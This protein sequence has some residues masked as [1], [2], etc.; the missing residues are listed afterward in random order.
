MKKLMLLLLSVLV[1]FTGCDLTPSEGDALQVKIVCDT[2]IITTDPSSIVLKE[3]EADVSVQI[4][5]M[6]SKIGSYYVTLG[7]TTKIPVL[8]DN[9]FF[10]S[11]NDVFG[12]KNP[13]I[14]V[15]YQEQQE[16]TVFKVSASVIGNGSLTPSGALMFQKGT[17]VPYVAKADFDSKLVAW[18]VDG[19]RTKATSDTC[20][21]EIKKEIQIVAVF[22]KRAIYQVTAT[23]VNGTVSSGMI[24]FYEGDSAL[25]S[26]Q[27]NY[28]YDISRLIV[29]GKDI[30]PDT[31][32]TAYNN[33][34]VE[35]VFEKKLEWYLCNVLWSRDT[36]YINGSTYF[37]P[38]SET[39]NF[40]E[41]GTYIRTLYG[42]TTHNN[43]WSINKSA[44]SLILNLGKCA[45]LV[46][47]LKD[48][49]L[50][51]FSDTTG[52][53]TTMVY[54]SIPK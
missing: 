4:I 43:T 41:N 36:T 42:T 30:V 33:S 14:H 3:G 38:G 31:K 7:E 34:S 48:N 26:A 37:E 25:V 13:E 5:N 40:S 50:T 35:F 49:K 32:Y 44:T 11:Y 9:T 15:S 46:K 10:V 1:I 8:S 21:L 54:H 53:P 27:G 18:I 29:N 20:I 22:E 51:I 12:I 6:N 2:N 19:N 47:V 28:G 39:L 45:F 52:Y 23:A 24:S 17:F 16:T